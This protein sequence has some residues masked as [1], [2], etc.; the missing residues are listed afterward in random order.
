MVI[1]KQSNN[2]QRVKV[3]ESDGY[4]VIPSN[5]V[6]LDP[7]IVKCH[8]KRLS[9]TG[10]AVMTSLGFSCQS[11]TS[12]MIRLMAGLDDMVMS[13]EPRVVTGENVKQI[14][15]AGVACDNGWVLWLCGGP[16]SDLIIPVNF[17]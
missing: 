8:S 13:Y 9:S 10:A 17:S 3:I 2:G 14:W 11:L 16:D 15:V 5:S 4:N 7:Q 1:G 12:R 6:S